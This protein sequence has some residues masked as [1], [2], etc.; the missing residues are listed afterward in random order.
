MFR[1]NVVEE[2]TKFKEHFW[3]AK[4]IFNYIG[5]NTYYMEYEVKDRLYGKS[6]YSIS[7]LIKCG[8]NGIYDF[9]DIMVKIIK[10]IGII[11]FT[12]S[13]V[14]LL[15]C[16]GKNIFG[17]LPIDRIN[18]IIFVL[19]FIGGLQIVLLSIIANYIYNTYIESKQRPAYIVKQ[20]LYAKDK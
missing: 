9:T 20:R 8:V 13:I 11:I 17:N 16:I 1:N 19:L 6:K 2:I 10:S 5:F 7:K 18:I 15:V 3:F 14:Y 4:G 12:I